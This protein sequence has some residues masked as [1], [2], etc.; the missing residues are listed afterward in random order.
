MS[1]T[2]NHTFRKE[3][4]HD[5]DILVGFGSG[6][7]ILVP[8][9]VAEQM[10]LLQKRRRIADQ[11]STLISVCGTVV[12]EGVS[13]V[14]LGLAATIARDTTHTVC[15]VD[16]DWSQGS[17]GENGSLLDIVEGD[18]EVGDVADQTDLP[19]LSLVHAGAAPLADRARIANSED[20]EIAIQQIAHDFDV[21]VLDVPALSSTAHAL[22]LATLAR[23]S[24]LV[25]RQGT[26]PIEQVQTVIS[27]LGEEQVIGVVL[28][29]ISQRTP[30]WL[31][32]PMVAS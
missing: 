25:V 21:V 26:V 17:V 2:S 10:R 8:F 24:I 32:N 29:E 6:Q 5:G 22:T 18:A 15:L 19:R 27:D 16:L 30:T 23:E 11:E 31:V 28:N 12:G 3:N 1:N 20:M 13:S 4:A 9:E 7:S 14:A